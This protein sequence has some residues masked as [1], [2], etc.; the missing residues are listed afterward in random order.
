[1]KKDK[2]IYPSDK[3][4][5]NLLS[6]RCN[7]HTSEG[8]A[9]RVVSKAKSASLK[10]KRRSVIPWIAASGIAAAVLLLI[11]T[12]YNDRTMDISSE[13]HLSSIAMTEITADSSVVSVKDA[14]FR[15][16]INSPVLRE[17]EDSYAVSD[18]KTETPPGRGY[19][20]KAV[21]AIISE[22]GATVKSKDTAQQNVEI[23]PD[24]KVKSGPMADMSVAYSYST[25]EPYADCER[26]IDSQNAYIDKMR[27]DI[28]ATEIYIR[29]VREML[30]E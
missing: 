24:D 7:F 16:T 4:I 22:D 27:Y 14:G 8:F 1:M 30:A 9:E 26:I 2:N 17:R 12:I 29:S 18:N 28:A 15:D 13:S 3:D 25:P 19:K 23:S 21:T 5:E 11:V 6:P 20:R 10:R